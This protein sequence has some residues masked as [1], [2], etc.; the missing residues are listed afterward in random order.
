M[1]S[2]KSSIQPCS[3]SLEHPEHYLQIL[4]KNPGPLQELFLETVE[5]EGLFVY[6][7]YA[8]QQDLSRAQAD[9]V[10]TRLRAYIACAIFD[11]CQA[12]KI[13]CKAGPLYG[14]RPSWFVGNLPVPYS[15]VE[16]SFSTDDKR[17]YQNV[18]PIMLSPALFRE[19]NDQITQLA[20]GFRL[21]F[22]TLKV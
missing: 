4:V 22:S 19:R 8:W 5:V 17:M 12:S 6:L 16:A 11:A 20:K 10:D 13:R 3:P 18:G 21:K 14:I 9:V 15:L 2:K 1:F 7:E